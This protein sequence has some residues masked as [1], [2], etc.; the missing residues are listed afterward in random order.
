MVEGKE[1]NIERREK[2]LKKVMGNVDLEIE[3]EIEKIESK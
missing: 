2:K 3:R 1:G